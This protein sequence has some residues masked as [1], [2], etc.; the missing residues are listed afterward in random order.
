MC[1][2]QSEGCVFS[3]LNEPAFEYRTWLR[4]RAV[5]LCGESYV[6][7]MVMLQMVAS[8]SL[9]TFCR[10]EYKARRASKY[11]ITGQNRVDSVSNGHDPSGVPSSS[12]LLLAGLFCPIFWELVRCMTSVICLPL[13]PPGLLTLAMRY[14]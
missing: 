2:L 11:E 3:R 7:V 14:V 1:E 10:N 8:C 5:F 12:I 6:G 13:T 9:G 4:C